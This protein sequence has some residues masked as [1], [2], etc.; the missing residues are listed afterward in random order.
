MGSNAVPFLVGILEA[1]PSILAELADQGVSKYYLKHPGGPPPRLLNALP[2]ADR[3]EGR[4]EAA[5]FM[6]GQIGPEAAAA[7]PTL[8]RIYTDTNENWRIESELGG[9]LASMGEKGM[10]LFPQYLSWLT[11]ADPVIQ[12][13]GAGFLESIGPKAQAALPA[14]TKAADSHNRNVATTAARALWSIGRQTNIVLRVHTKYLQSPPDTACQLA[15][16]YLG[17]MGPAAAP[18]VPL[19]EPFLRDSDSV[20]RE[21]AEK[22]LRAIDPAGFQSAQRQMNQERQATIASLIKMLRSG[23]FR[24]KHRAVEV[25]GLFGPDARDAVPALIEALE[26]S[27]NDVPAAFAVTAT[28]D[29]Q[30]QAAEALAEIGSDAVAAVPAL[31]TLA[32]AGSWHGPS[33]C[34]ALGRIGPGA[35]QAIPVL[36]EALGDDNAPVRF[37]AAEALTRIVPQQC[38]NAVAVLRALQHDPKLARVWQS[39]GDG[40]A[41]PAERLDF[42]S[43]LSRQFRI[44]ASVPLWRLGLEQQP[45]VAGLLDELEGPGHNYNL[46]CIELLGELGPAARPALPRLIPLVEPNNWSGLRRAAAIAIRKIDSAQADKLNLPGVLAIP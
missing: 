1:K 33:F 12:A 43:P 31:A 16:I 27:S 42:N 35:R 37:A 2:S 29:L 6:L 23:I 41:H 14:L 32:H 19:I 7:I 44:S 18:A 11:N 45:P 8:F 4:R 10:V 36:E 34:K 20:I 28:A 38:S 5:A 40:L 15:I 46:W 25:L 3:V 22:A 21:Q 30:R 13:I 39:N 17:K 24:E 9:A 26:C